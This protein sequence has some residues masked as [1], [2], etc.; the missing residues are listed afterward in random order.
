M[1]DRDDLIT[2][3]AETLKEPVGLSSDLDRRI[4]AE[5]ERLPTP[6][7]T[8]RLRRVYEWLR[9]GRHVTVSPIG[10][11]AAAAV[12]VAVVLGGRA[13]LL[14]PDAAD[15]ELP[16]QP[17]S[18]APVGQTMQFVLVAPGATSVALLG[19]FNDWNSAATPME[20]Q[21]GSGVWSVTVPLTP[22]RYRYAFLV[23][24]ERWLRDP[25]APRA[26]EDDFGRPNSVLTIGGS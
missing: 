7:G 2:R 18:L 1:T 8:P 5:I 3:A 11:L 13:W 12:V 24:G 19:D 20:P 22:G 9:T 6:A 15:E 23:D 17:A 10:A 14:A 25:A 4:M 16:L 21:N 26:L